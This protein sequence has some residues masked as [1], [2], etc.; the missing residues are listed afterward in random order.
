MFHPAQQFQSWRRFC[1]S[2]DGK[3]V[4]PFHYNKGVFYDC[5]NF[6]A[7]HKWCSLT[8]TFEGRWKYC[9]ED[10][11]CPPSEALQVVVLGAR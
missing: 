2:L 1:F 10:G 3:C 11:E 5:I 6:K 4:F 9:S 8:H 7:K